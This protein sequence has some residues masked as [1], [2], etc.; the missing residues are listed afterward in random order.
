MDV[1][2]GITVVLAVGGIESDIPHCQSFSIPDAAR[3]LRDPAAVALGS[4][5]TYST[6]KAGCTSIPAENNS[7]HK[8]IKTSQEGDCFN[9]K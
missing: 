6:C 1:P 9:H 2:R 7:I 3:S 8:Q 4:A 5:S